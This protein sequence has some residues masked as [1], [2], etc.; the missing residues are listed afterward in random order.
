MV[1][2][3]LDNEIF[4]LSAL[5]QNKNLLSKRAQVALKKR[6]K[7]VARY[8]ADDKLAWAYPSISYVAHPVF[9]EKLYNSMSRVEKRSIK[10]RLAG[11]VSTNNLNLYGLAMSSEKLMSE[12]E[13]IRLAQKILNEEKKREAPVKG[14]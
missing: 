7:Q 12:R 13:Q 2:G 1:Q 6:P 11:P 3:L 14:F 10:K 9:F 5:E 8:W 4:F